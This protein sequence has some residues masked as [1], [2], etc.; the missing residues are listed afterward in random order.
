LRN[1]TRE[2]ALPLRTWRDAMT[3]FAVLYD[4]RFTTPQA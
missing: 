1:I 2:W 4:E 3:Q